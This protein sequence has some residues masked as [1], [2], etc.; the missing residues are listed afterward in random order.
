MTGEVIT[1]YPG[2][3]P[4]EYWD[5]CVFIGGSAPGPSASAGP[6]QPEVIALLRERWASDG[7]LV[8]FVSEQAGGARYDVAG[9]L[10]DWYDRALDV[11]DGVMFWWPDDAGR[12]RL[13]TPPAG[14]S[15]RQAGGGGAPP[16]PPA[17]R[18]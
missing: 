4:P 10:I 5:A 8:V 17:R 1:V 16:P 14:W 12:L 11:A 3:Q 6:W 15:A 18:A 2:Q 7:R 13:Y 9:P